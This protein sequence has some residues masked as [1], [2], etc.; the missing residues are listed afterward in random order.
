MSYFSQA[1]NAYPSRIDESLEAFHRSSSSSTMFSDSSSTSSR[2]YPSL[3][4]ILTNDAPFPYSFDAF[5]NFLS[6]NHCMETVEFTMDAAK[7][8]TSY[9]AG[10][11]KDKLV[12]MWNRLVDTYIRS[13]GP[14]ELN[15]T[16]DVKARFKLLAKEAMSGEPPEPANLARPVEMVKEIMK[17]NAYMQFIASTRGLD[18]SGS[19]RGSQTR[20]DSCMHRLDTPVEIPTS[21]LAVDQHQQQ[22][23]S[24]QQPVSWM[25]YPQKTNQV[26]KTSSSE[27]LYM[28]DEAN[29]KTGSTT[30][31]AAINPRTPPE[32]PCTVH[33]HTTYEKSSIKST[34][35]TT[36]PA[37]AP[38]RHPSQ[39]RKMS[40]RLKWRR[41]SSDNQQ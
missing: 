34:T 5:V 37:M 29:L 13:D 6:Q 35:A 4:D 2:K 28:G 9:F 12:L 33:H 1:H 22:P 19:R 7:Y 26:S 11:S 8:T 23:G 32:S 36:A 38:T 39:W 30:T 27:S 15:L 3:D 24:W 16:C 17:E 25:H 41:G 20:P 14:K 18:R 21:G 31:T 10:V 40:Q